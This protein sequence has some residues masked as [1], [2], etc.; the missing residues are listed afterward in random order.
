MLWCLPCGT[1]RCL[2]SKGPSWL[3]RL[4]RLCDDGRLDGEQTLKVYVKGKPSR[5]HQRVHSMHRK[6]HRAEPVRTMLPEP[7]APLG[8]DKVDGPQQSAKLAANVHYIMA[9][10]RN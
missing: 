6:V 10:K 4:V 2:V 7:L 3:G 9:H 5:F 1:L 8:Y